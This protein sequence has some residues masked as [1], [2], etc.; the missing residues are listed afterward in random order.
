[1]EGRGSRRGGYHTDRQTTFA[2]NLPR[3]AICPLA[4]LILAAHRQLSRAPCLERRHQYRRNRRPNEQK[5]LKGKPV[6]RPKHAEERE[7]KRNWKQSRHVKP[8][9]AIRSVDNARLDEGDAGRLGSDQ[10]D[11]AGGE[12]HSLEAQ[13]L[14][15]ATAA[16]SIDSVARGARRPFHERRK[17]NRQQ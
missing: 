2:A 7:K 4:A 9:F 5:L 8:I 13:A 16:G 3:L 14:T 10:A 11:S 17:A 15:A 1:M 12:K 6:N